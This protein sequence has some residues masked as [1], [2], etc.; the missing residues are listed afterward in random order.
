MD[1]GG[2]SVLPALVTTSQS[3]FVEGN[4]IGVSD[5]DARVWALLKDH[6]SFQSSLQRRHTRLFMGPGEKMVLLTYQADATFGWR[7]FISDGGQQGVSCAFFRNTSAVQS[8]ALINEA[9]ALAWDRWPGE[10]LYTYVDATALP[11]GKRPGYCFEAAGWHRC[12]VTKV[13]GLL[14]LEKL[15]E[16]N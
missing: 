13:H 4:W 11:A 16:E 7:K 1:A 10:R 14:I 8:S 12:G 5:G 6:Y 3:P 15:S 9:C 2:L